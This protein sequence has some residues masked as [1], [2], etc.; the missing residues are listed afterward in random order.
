MTAEVS[1]YDI[2]CLRVEHEALEREVGRLRDALR[3]ADDRNF[4]R[5][6]IIFGLSIAFTMFVGIHLKHHLA[7][8]ASA[9]EAPA[10]AHTNTGHTS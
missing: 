2:Q 4:E 1:R 10:S 3:A 7:G 8:S 5:T 6:M 9:V